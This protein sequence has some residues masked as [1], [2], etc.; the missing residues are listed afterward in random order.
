MSGDK[1]EK[2]EAMTRMMFNPVPMAIYFLIV[3]M[4]LGL[5]I[6]FIV[7]AIVKREAVLPPRV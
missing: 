1:L 6:S 2:A 5:I 4:V 7:A 3:G